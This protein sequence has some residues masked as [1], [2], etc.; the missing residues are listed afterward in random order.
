MALV[1]AE[2]R[3]TGN[4]MCQGWRIAREIVIECFEGERMAERSRSALENVIERG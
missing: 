2:G 4:A 1:L 3:A